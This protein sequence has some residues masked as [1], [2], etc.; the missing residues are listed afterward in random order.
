MANQ[1][2]QPE[3]FQCGQCLKKEG[4]PYRVQALET[5]MVIYVRCR[6][7][8]HRWSVSQDVRHAERPPEAT[9]ATARH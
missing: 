1:S 9:S 5:P 3:P 7:C 8:G 2:L 4:E 6:S